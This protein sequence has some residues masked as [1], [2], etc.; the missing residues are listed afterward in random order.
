TCTCWSS[1][2]EY[3]R[4]PH[5]AQFPVLTRNLNPHQDCR[6][7]CSIDVP[8]WTAGL[9]QIQRDMCATASNDGTA[10]AVSQD[11]RQLFARSGPNREPNPNEG[12]GKLKCVC[13]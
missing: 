5:A 1:N 7:P 4:P 2:A 6:L 13:W 3:R 11:E 12:V 9:S 10:T 8:S